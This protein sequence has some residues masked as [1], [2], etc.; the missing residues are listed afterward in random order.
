MKQTP[1]LAIVISALA[2]IGLA[3]AVVVENPINLTPLTAAST[4]Y[5]QLSGAALLNGIPAFAA[6][7]GNATA[8][9]NFSNSNVFSKGL[10]LTLTA[11][12][13]TTTAKNF[14]IDPTS[15]IALT[16]ASVAGCVNSTGATDTH[17]LTLNNLSEA[18]LEGVSIA[19]GA[20]NTDV[21]GICNAW[22]V[23]QFETNATWT[24]GVTG[25]TVGLTSTAITSGG[26]AA[27]ADALKTLKTTT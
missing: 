12:S 23:A 24:A 18:Q 1:V 14:H 10:P 7:W 19:T 2:L 22:S 16:V 4:S 9:A 6:G 15:S 25:S 8:Y 5:E 20:A 3:G 13:S 27:I 11:V 21:S 26:S 17:T